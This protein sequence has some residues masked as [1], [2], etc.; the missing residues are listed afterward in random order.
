MNL[1]EQFTMYRKHKVLTLTELAERAGVTR[2]TVKNIELGKNVTIHNLIKV[3]NALDK[4]LV[5]EVVKKE[6]D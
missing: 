4:R 5:V 2:Q 1:A 6:R 3:A